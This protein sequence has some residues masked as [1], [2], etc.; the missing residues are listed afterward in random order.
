MSS[1]S[2]NPVP[3]PEEEESYSSWA[4]C[5]LCMLLIGALWMSYYL[6]VRRIRAVHE[7]VVSI[8]AGQ[9]TRP[10]PLDLAVQLRLDGS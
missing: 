1:S 4:L 9:L 7:T 8:F 10:R 2:P 6:Q 5:I 3:T